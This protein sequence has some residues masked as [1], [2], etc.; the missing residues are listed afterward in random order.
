MT[1]RLEV[2]A[3]IGSNDSMPVRMYPVCRD[4]EDHQRCFIAAW[5]GD[6]V[7]LEPENPDRIDEEC[8]EGYWQ[9]IDP[10][11]RYRSGHLL[12]RFHPDEPA[13][14]LP[15][16]EMAERFRVAFKE[17]LALA[18]QR[19]AGDG[20]GDEAIECIY[21]AARCQP[22]DPMG[23]ILC[24]AMEETVGQI[25]PAGLRALNRS[26][27]DDPARV[28]EALARIRREPIYAVFREYVDRARSLAAYREEREGVTLSR[29]SFLT[30]FK[31]DPEFIDRQR[32]LPRFSDMAI[33]A[34]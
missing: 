18:A 6:E 5:R 23:T 16:D 8:D 15:P 3:G 31:C 21:H 9:R 14:Y 24:I 1:R 10:P 17:T 25:P 28:R 26:L 13:V 12:A 4:A 32:V 30:R 20:P 22:D 34:A 11:I 2:V 33:S 19:L 7:I 27:P 29:R